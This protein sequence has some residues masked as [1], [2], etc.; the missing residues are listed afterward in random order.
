MNHRLDNFAYLIRTIGHIPGGNRSYYIDQSQPPFFSLMSQLL[1]QTDKYKNELEIEYKFWMTKR[2]VTLDSETI[3][4]RYYADSWNKP[5]PEVFL[6]DV[7]TAKK[8][9]NANIYLHLTAAGE[10]GWDFSS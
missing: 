2:A 6:E 3:L 10:C 9:K 1:G 8:L 5:R 4:N 7:Q